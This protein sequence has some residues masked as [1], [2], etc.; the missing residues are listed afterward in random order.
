MKGRREVGRGTSKKGGRGKCDRAGKKLIKI[1]QFSHETKNPLDVCATQFFEKWNKYWGQSFFFFLSE[2]VSYSPGWLQ[3]WYVAKTTFQ[4]SLLPSSKTTGMR[5]HTLV[6]A[7]LRSEHRASCIRGK[8]STN[9]ATSLPSEQIFTVLL[10]FLEWLYSFQWF[11]LE[12]DYLL[13]SLFTYLYGCQRSNLELQK[14]LSKHSH[15]AT[16]QALEI[17]TF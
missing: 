13:I 14:M 12:A 11:R 8:H 10:L 7:V 4:L 9:W 2:K 17:D 15:W 5:Q 6:Y 16:L 3:V 1:F